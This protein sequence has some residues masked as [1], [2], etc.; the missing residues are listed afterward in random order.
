MK[1]PRMTNQRPRP[2]LISQFATPSPIPPTNI[3]QDRTTN[4]E[5][6]PARW[7]YVRRMNAILAST[8]AAKAD[9]P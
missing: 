3:A 7:R 9:M 2:P 1:P 4:T 6:A 8:G 5:I